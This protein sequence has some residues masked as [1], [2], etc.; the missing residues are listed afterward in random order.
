MVEAEVA[1]AVGPRQKA[2]FDHAADQPCTA[3]AQGGRVVCVI[4]AA[5][6]N[7]QRAVMQVFQTL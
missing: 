2:V 1:H 7:H 3:T 6:V 5:G 4:I